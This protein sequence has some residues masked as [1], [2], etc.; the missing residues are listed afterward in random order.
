V[1]HY[2]DDHTI[3]E[4]LADLD[5]ARQIQALFPISTGWTHYRYAVNRLAGQDVTQVAED[6]AARLQAQK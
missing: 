6:A 5:R 3:I 4:I 1:I 2:Q